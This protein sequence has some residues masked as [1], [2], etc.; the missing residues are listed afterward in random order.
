MS[1]VSLYASDNTRYNFQIGSALIGG[2]Y[3]TSISNPYGFNGT[4][5]HGTVNGVTIPSMS[6]SCDW[7]LS[8]IDK[9]PQLISVGTDINSLSIGAN[10]SL[11]LYTKPNQQGTSFT[12]STNSSAV[13]ERIEYVSGSYTGYYYGD[14]P[15]IELYFVW[16][17]GAALSQYDNLCIYM[18]AGGDNYGLFFG[19][20]AHLN[21]LFTNSTSNNIQE[22]FSSGSLIS[23]SPGDEGF[24]PIGDIPDRTFGGGGTSGDV[25]DYHTDDIELPG[26]PDEST[27]SAIMS[28]MINIYQLNKA[29]LD[30]LGKALFGSEGI[31]GLITKLQNSFLNPLDAIISLQVFPCTP[32]L[33]SSENIKVFDWS[34]VST[35]LG[36][37]AV[38]NRLSNQYKTYNFGTLNIAE[39]WHSYLDYESTSME[40]YLPFIGSV[41]IPIAEVM[42]GSVEV[43]YTVDF[44]TGMC[45]ANVRCSKSVP[46]SSGRS[47]P[48]KTEHSYMGNCSVQIPLNNVSYGNIIGS[49]M[50]AAS[51][52]LRTGNAGVALASVVESGLS[53][54]LSPTVKTKGTINA[55]AG[56]CSVLYPYLSII[57]PITAEAQNFQT[58]EGY[59]SY[60]Y[61][62]LGSY[63]GLCVCDDINL[64][65]V[66]GA[67]D[68]ELDEIRNI[69]KAGIYV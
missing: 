68:D 47:V 13:I 26:A 65:N 6:F 2:A 51:S 62:T 52:G 38:G 3:G 66:P 35:K 50:Q 56:F 23:A 45:V 61:G 64:S 7:G 40:L 42:N 53:G 22:R 59:P 27:A 16:A 33:G 5:P 12:F 69:C 32:S 10:S 21:A 9:K 4:M 19:G 20:D 44:L 31:D 28:G 34:C 1:H 39:I 57:R 43:E 17:E 46:L 30:L 18:N 67:T 49:L 63:A 54:G 15:A 41:D 24:K 25:P 58:V 11:T 48:Q 36:T 29:N 14:Y 8:W 55:N 60:I 37:S